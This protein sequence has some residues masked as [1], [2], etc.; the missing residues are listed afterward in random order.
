VA[1]EWSPVSSSWVAS[2]GYDAEVRVLYVRVLGG[3]YYRYLD[4]PEDVFREFLAAPSQG[5]YLN[6]NIKPY[7]TSEQVA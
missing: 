4:V 3:G 5:A 1:L 2:V 7:Y 6:K